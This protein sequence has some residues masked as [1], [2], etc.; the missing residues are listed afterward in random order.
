M[1]GIIHTMGR[2]EAIFLGLTTRQN[3]E[4]MRINNLQLLRY[5]HNDNP[6]IL[7]GDDESVRW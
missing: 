2:S 5:A 7:F 3:L 1:P 6:N 4:S